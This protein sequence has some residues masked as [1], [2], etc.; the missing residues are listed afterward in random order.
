MSQSVKE[1]PIPSDCSLHESA[2]SAYF[3]DA[4]ATLVPRSD[5]TA[6]QLYAAVMRSTPA[7]VDSLMRARNGVVAWFGLKNLGV[8]SAVPNATEQPLQAGQR[9]GIFS[10]VRETPSELVIQDTDKHLTAQIAVIKQ[11]VD[12]QHDRLIACTV[13]HTHNLLGRV[14]LTPVGRAHKF[15]VPAVLRGATAAILQT[16]QLSIK[17]DLNAVG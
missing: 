11:T 16:I 10:F 3:A 8:L 13:V 7:W 17:N 15:I 6:T 14:Y 9:I 5:L 1:I 4:F 2:Q 12:S